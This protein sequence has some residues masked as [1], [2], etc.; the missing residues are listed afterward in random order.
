[1][2]TSISVVVDGARVDVKTWRMGYTTATGA[3]GGPPQDC[4]HHPSSTVRVLDEQELVLGDARFFA[5]RAACMSATVSAPRVPSPDE[6]RECLD[7]ALDGALAPDID[8]APPSGAF[9]DAFER[10]VTKGGTVW[11]ADRGCRP[12]TVTPAQR[13]ANH[14]NLAFTVVATDRDARGRPTRDTDSLEYDPGCKTLTWLGT[15]HDYGNGSGA[16]WSDGAAW[17][18]ISEPDEP[19]RLPEHFNAFYTHTAC[20]RSLTSRPKP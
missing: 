12:L 1:V 4:G 3:G 7:V 11:A 6:A 14:G 20:L 10:L 13:G 17:G 9:V 8:A 2:H 18:P 5:D 15:S 19:E 16:G